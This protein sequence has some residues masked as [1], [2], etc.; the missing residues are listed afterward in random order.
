MTPIKSTIVFAAGGTGGH[1]FPAEA[2]ATEL[3]ARGYKVVLITDER[4]KRYTD[5]FPGGDVRQIRAATV[6]GNPIKRFFALILILGGIL[7][8]FTMLGRLKPV[9]A[10]GFGGYPSLPTMVAASLRG[11]P[12]ALHDPNAVLGRV[13]KLLASYVNVIGAAFD[14]MEGIPAKQ[15]HKV[16][17][18]GNPIRS[19][20]LKGL[21]QPYQAP[22]ADG[23]INLVVFGGSQ[24]AQVF[25]ETV[26]QAIEQLPETVK[27]RLILTQ[28]ARPESMDD[29]QRDYDDMGVR[30]DV[31]PF[32]ADLPERMAAAHLVIARSGASTVTELA[33]MGRPSILVPLPTAMD[34][35]QTVNARVLT[36]RG[37]A[38]LMPQGAL[39]PELLADKLRSLL[40]D[41]MTL[42]QA[43]AAALKAGH[44]DA[45]SVFAD[46]V[47]GLVAPQDR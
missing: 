27:A 31:A 44:H 25:S 17:L 29:V 13:N 23:P 45:T 18:V 4:G 5:H 19:S 22:T 43:A 3:T 47:E 42:N 14:N 20:V 39:T 1:M 9:A 7:Q 30:A 33:A 35:H 26:P 24:G 34:D 41:P 16:K 28:Q 46:V 32:F 6:A 10:V 2:L 8:A 15:A 11:V 12:T 40:G 21:D 37:A 36:A 38:W